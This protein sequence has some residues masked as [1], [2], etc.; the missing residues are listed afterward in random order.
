MNSHRSTCSWRPAPSMFFLGLLAGS[1]AGCGSS[2]STQPPAVANGT[3]AFVQDMRAE[4]LTPDGSTAVLTDLTS[5]TGD[6]YLYDT[7]TDV[8]LLAGQTGDAL[9]DFTTGISSNLRVSAIHAKPEEAGLWTAANGWL[10]LGNIYPVGCEYDQTTHDA[11]Q[12]GGWD[13]CADGS[14]TV[15]L[16]WNGCNAEAFRWTDAGGAGTF[17][18]LDILGVNS[19]ATKIADDGSIAGGFADTALVDR[20]P[21]IW[22]ASGA[23]FLIPSG[24]VFTDDSPGEV[25]SISSDGSMVAGIW[26]L[27]GFYWTQAAGVV[28]LG[29]VPGG[30]TYPNA[31]AADGQLIF[32][33]TSEGFFDPSYPFVWTAATGMRSLNDILAANHIV[34]PPDITLDNVKAA[35]ADGSVLVGNAYDL[36]FRSYAFVLQLPVSAYGL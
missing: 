8:E 23:G 15:G 19:R 5:I 3:I 14:A 1:L 29:T 33:K 36:T 25:L 30:Q 28:K 32:G 31:I 17:I 9:F 24:G 2:H 21:A 10:D 35:S 6:F 34:I 4:D 22:D 7:A 20:W 13:V 26:N 16:V 18:P 27:E 12:S 11:N